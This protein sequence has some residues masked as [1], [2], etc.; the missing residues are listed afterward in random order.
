MKQFSIKANIFSFKNR[1]FEK[2]EI[3][4]DNGVISKIVPRETVDDLFIVPGFVDSH[5]HIESSMLSPVEFAKAAVENGVLGAVCDPHEIANVCGVSGVKFMKELDDS[6]PFS[7]LFGAPSCVPATN[8]ESSGAVLSSKDLEILFNDKVVS[9]IGE[10]MNFPGVICGDKDVLDIVALGERYNVPVDG[11]APGLSGGDLGRYV[12]A[13]V[14]TDH[15]CVTVEEALE[16]ISLGMKV[17][18]REGSAAKDFDALCS[19]IKT[20]NADVM[21]CTDD[22]H[23]D[24]LLSGYLKNTYLKA[25]AKGFDFADIFQVMSKNPV[26]FYGVDLG[27]LGVGDRAD[28]VVLDNLEKYSVRSVYYGGVDLLKDKIDVKTDRV[29]NNFNVDFISEADIK[30]AKEQGLLKV[31]ECT[32]GSLVTSVLK[33]EPKVDGGFVVSDA[34]ND[35]LKIVVVNRYSN[36]KPAVG[37]IKGIGLKKGAMVSSVSH[38]SHNIIACGVNDKLIAKAVNLVI[39]NKGGVGFVD[40]DYESILPLPIAGLMSDLPCVDVARKYVEVDSLAKKAG[41]SLGAPYMTLAFMSLLVIPEIKLGDRGLFD[42]KTFNFT[43]L[44]E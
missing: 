5:V 3:F 23:P 39:E 15:E 33:V 12:N 11:H 13:G 10:M 8:L 43:S 6:V 25:V 22:M 16:K 36:S 44:F 29:I 35:I 32:D 27:M 26:D 1:C 31:I 18:I 37:F 14:Q 2:S 38:D 21:A 40:D 30:V 19:L 9:F 17:L 20:N 4:V 24:T 34:V 7:F 42:F 41:S 28:F